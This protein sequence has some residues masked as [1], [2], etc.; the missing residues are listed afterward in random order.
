[1]AD[2]SKLVLYNRNLVI[3]VHTVLLVLKNE[4]GAK[5]QV[6]IVILSFGSE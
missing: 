3:V 6:R 4:L 2:R 1:M 5:V